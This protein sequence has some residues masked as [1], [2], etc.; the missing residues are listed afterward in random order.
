MET[1]RD[2]I[3]TVNEQNLKNVQIKKKTVSKTQIHVAAKKYEIF[4]DQANLLLLCRE[5]SECLD[6]FLHFTLTC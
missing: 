4:D 2:K 1:W 5:M 6:G 3:K